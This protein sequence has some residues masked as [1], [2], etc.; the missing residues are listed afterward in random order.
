[1]FPGAIQF[2][3]QAR[4]IAFIQASQ[5][6]SWDREFFKLGAFFVKV[7]F[8]LFNKTALKTTILVKR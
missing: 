4:K 8:L 7:L 2:K 1:M 5:A 3:F 6:Q